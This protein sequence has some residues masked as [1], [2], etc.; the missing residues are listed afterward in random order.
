VSVSASSSRPPEWRSLLSL[1]KR[2]MNAPNL[3]IQ[4][5]AIAETVSGLLNCRAQVWL[6]EM[7]LPKMASGEVRAASTRPTPAMRQAC[8]QQRIYIRNGRSQIVAVPIINQDNVLGAIQA[9]RPIAQPFQAEEINLL[10]GIAS[11]AAIALQATRQRWIDQ[12]R[13]EQLLLVRQVSAQLVNVTDLDE[14]TCRVTR[15]IQETFDYYYVAIFT[16]EPGQDSLTFRHSAGPRRDGAGQREQRSS[17]RITARLGQGIIGIAAQSGEDIIACEAIHDARYRHTDLLPET[18]SEA[19]FP[20]KIE[21]RILGVLDVQSDQPNAFHDID[22]LVLRALA[23]NIAI[24]VEG[25]RLYGALQHRAEQLSSVAEI[26][27]AITSIL[28]LDALLREVVNLLQNRLGY[29]HIQIFTVQPV[30]RK[31]VY[32]IG[33]GPRD[34]A[35]RASAFA[36]SMDD[37][38][39]IIPWVI[40][41]SD[42]VLANDLNTEPRYRPTHEFGIEPRAELTV[43]LVF[44]GE[45]L[46]ALD[47]QSEQPNAFSDD[48]RFLF[49]ALADNIAVAIHNAKLYRS[50]RWRRQVAD[51]MR[52][53][54]GLLSANADLGQVLEIILSE[55]ESALPCDAAAIW[56]LEENGDNPTEGTLPPLRLAAYRCSASTKPNGP[57]SPDDILPTPWLAEALAAES[58]CIRTPASAFDPLGA[59]LA[60][61]EDHS[62][63]AAPMRTGNQPVGVLTL[64]HRKPGRYGAESRAMTETFAS[65]AAVAIENTRLYEA[66]HEQAWVATVLLQ[67]SEATQ[68]L[69]DLDELLRNVVE[70]TPTLVGINA[71]GLL[72]YEESSSVFV[73]AAAYGFTPAQL[74]EFKRWYIPRGIAPAFDQLIALKKPILL[75]VFMEDDLLAEQMRAALGEQ[76]LSPDTALVLFPLVARGE[77]LGALLVDYSN[78]GSEGLVQDEK[79]SIIQ[80]IA[81]QTAIAIE[82]IRLLK[83]QKEEAYVSVALLQVAQAVVSLTDLEDILESIVRLTPILVGVRRTAIFL[84]DEASDSFILSQSYGFPA[85][86][87]ESLRHRRYRPDEFPLLQAVKTCDRPIFHPLAD[88]P[89]SPL[90]WERLP[91]AAAPLADSAAE[92]ISD[93]PEMEALAL[94]SCLLIGLP[95]SVKGNVLGVMLVEETDNDP[96]HSPKHMRPRRLEIITGI[97]QQAALAIQNDLLQREVVERERLEREMQLAREIQRA[98]LPHQLPL[99]PHWDLDSRWRPARQVGGDFYDVLQLPDH[100]LGLVV[101]DVADKGMPAAL[102]M[103]LVRTLL[104]AAVHETASPA[105]VLQRVNTLLIPDA[106]NGMF[107]TVVYAVLS[108][109][110]GEL[111]YANAGHNPPLWLHH[112]EQYIERLMPSS[113]ALGVEHNLHIQERTIVLRPGDCL[114]LYTDGVTDAFSPE[115]DLYGE[116]RLQQAL[117]SANSHSAKATLDAIEASVLAFTAGQP[118]FDDL[119]MLLVQHTSDQALP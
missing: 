47:A 36:F 45:V 91:V 53:V 93:T 51:S 96:G 113:M 101:A 83:A 66:A 59:A 58:P 116:M 3:E 18:R 37:L 13:V 2:L 112:G 70:I 86:V 84:W 107:V 57:C 38:D 39:G 111:V 19:A 24:A 21:G 9:R 4:S 55:L 81:H 17:P 54:A 30:S 85:A 109:L 105:A 40:R 97:S 32:A 22:T 118:L 89:Q 26:S 56:L 99:V 73:P 98:F 1:G 65:Y 61:P 34:E 64:A 104:R 27:N 94:D 110:S 115:E 92:E 87:E 80:G 77:V 42:T 75:S 68:A 69:S 78:Q 106:R 6:D 11:Q 48:D 49:E 16:L 88:P 72:T 50:E 82:N 60:F 100:R 12:W 23:D 52:E 41:N 29:S 5:Q 43:P 35:L 117:L 14:L 76:I 28:E 31:I 79:L 71:C 119:T 90:D 74:E 103:T 25:A 10:D 63:I 67:V 108:P 8:R 44:G 15:L 62:A 33:N 7:R 46:G 102:F 20:L 95:L 114:L